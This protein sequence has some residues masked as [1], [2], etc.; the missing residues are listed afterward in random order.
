MYVQL[1]MF[2][3]IRLRAGPAHFYPYNMPSKLENN[4]P[5]FLIF[6]MVARFRSI[7]TRSYRDRDNTP[8]L[9]KYNANTSIYGAVEKSRQRRSRHV[10]VLT[11]YQ[12]VPR[13]KQR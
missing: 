2:R 8:F 5:Q 9:P 3:R 12:Y 4:T 11:S 1:T 10:S 7:I 6:Q 13:A